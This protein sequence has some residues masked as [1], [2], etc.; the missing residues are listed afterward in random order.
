MLDIGKLGNCMVG[1]C[2]L[3]LFFSCENTEEEPF[4]TTDFKGKI[5][6]SYKD[7]KEFWR[8]IPSPQ[9]GTPNVLIFLMDDMGFAQLGA[10]GGVI[11]TPNMDKLAANGLRYTNFHTTALCSPSRA[12]ILAGRYPH[13]IGIGSHSLTAMGFPGYNATIPDNAKSIARQLKESGFVNY[14]LGKWDHTPLWEVSQVGPFDRWPSGEGFDYFYGFMAADIDCF[15]SSLI[16]DHTP[17]NPWEG[18]NNYILE[19]D[20]AN[21]AI[22]YISGHKSVKPDLP[23]MMYWAPV[24]MHAP[25][26]VPRSYIEAY[27]GKFDGGWDEMR[28]QILQNQIET[29]IVPPNTQLT[30]KPTDIK[31]WD[32][33]TEEEKRLYARQMETFAGK[34]THVDEQI[35]KVVDHLEKIGELDNTLI[36]LTSDNGASGEGGLAGAHNEMR[37]LNGLPSSLE[38]NLPFY[39]DWGTTSGTY[40]HYHAGWALA[41][42]T[43][44]K[45][46]KQMAHRGGQTD[47]M[48]V[49]WPKG[50]KE[51]GGIRTQYHHIADIAPTILEVTQQ[52]FH[53]NIEGIAQRP[54][55]GI[56]FAY[57]FDKSTV[58][59]QRNEQLFELF[60]NRALYKDGW[61]AVTIHGNRM[62][63]KTNSI[64]PFEE[65]V[66]E[67]YHVA[68]DFAEANDLAEQHPEKLKELINRWDELAWEQ[69][70]YPMHDDMIS[71]YS[72][73]QTRLF[74][75][76]KKFVYFHPGAVR[77]PEMTSAPIKNKSY[78]ISTT[79][80]YGGQ[81]EGVIVACGGTPGGYSLFVKNGQVHYDYN[82]FNEQ[83]YVLSAP[84]KNGLNKLA[85]NFTKTGNF[86]GTGA[87]SING[88]IVDEVAMPLTHIT[89]Y[90]LAETF[91]VGQDTGTPVSKQY[92]NRFE[93]KGSLDSVN[94]ELLE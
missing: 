79:I 5:E 72:K 68:E 51:K 84:L 52:P 2:L 17:I 67:L 93:Y 36:I 27:K 57:T 78:Q 88:K 50:I 14:A 91:D 13:S 76:Q 7:S 37:M 80:P 38:N 44:F 81:E 35:G 53:E 19:E 58:A 18:K 33:L 46:F 87:L 9:K 71:R 63:W 64:T 25:H 16:Q 42:N 70:V 31:D 49:H 47:A 86:K 20:M 61:K 73:L 3:F 24:A 90:T 15:R 89:S 4:S 69:Q 28:I 66:W 12:S 1:M 29:G 85:F 10:Y 75:D 92:T 54:F 62:P 77:I 30:E 56:S 8:D 94:I 65:D 32:D 39:E 22:Q 60:G 45:Y 83:H 82:L 26:H 74:G 21:K 55:D 23:F 34:L 41:G 59:S 11:A 48:I 6:R 43:P 40:P